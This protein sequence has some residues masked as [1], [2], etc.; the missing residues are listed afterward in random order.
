[1][2]RKNGI[3]ACLKV[4]SSRAKPTAGQTVLGVMSALGQ[5]QTCAVQ[6]SMSALPP[7]AT[8]NAYSRKGSCPL[9]PWKRT[10]AVQIEMPAM[11]QK[12][13]LCDAGVSVEIPPHNSRPLL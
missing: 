5:K 7:I 8:A 2:G 11:G 10:C 1:M 9:Y 6:T 3:P 12:Q 4:R 13:T